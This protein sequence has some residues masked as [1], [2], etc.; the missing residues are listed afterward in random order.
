MYCQ[1]CAK[2]C[3]NENSHRNHERCC[4]VNPNRRYKNGM[5]GKKGTNQFMKA[6]DNG[7]RFIV[8]EDTRR[9][10]GIAGTGRILSVKTKNK[11]SESMKLAHS[12]G[13]AWNIGKSRWNNEPS[14][15][16]QFFMRVIEN[17]FDDK[18]FNREHCV[19]IYSIDFAWP[20]L[21]KA[22]EIDGDQHERFTDVKERDIRKD[23]LLNE[24]GWVVH[25]IK[26]KDMMSNTKGEISKA[27]SF[28]H[29]A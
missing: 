10:L 29:S 4:P 13:K 14:W 7:L 15:P 21:K 28:I 25:R 17:E 11:I 24:H 2:E 9:K 3:K 22:I 6:K 20:H 1:F 16:E 8:T 18:N 19:G 27:I 5:T 12:S 23:R 26:W